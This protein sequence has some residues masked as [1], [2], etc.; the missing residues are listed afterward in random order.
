MFKEFRLSVAPKKMWFR[1]HHDDNLLIVV[2]TRP[3]LGK[4]LKLE[5]RRLPAEN[6]ASGTDLAR[7]PSAFR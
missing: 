2:A 3:K 7:Y 1:L 6:K 5:C 4:F